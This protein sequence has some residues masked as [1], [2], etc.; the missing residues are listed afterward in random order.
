MPSSPAEPL[1][2]AE[3]VLRA[4]ARA[5]DEALQAASS[6]D[7]HAVE[8]LLTATDRLLAAP[9][10]PPAD[11]TAFEAI[12]ADARA[13]HARLLAL[14]SEVRDETGAELGRTRRGRKALGAY[15]GDPALGRRVESRA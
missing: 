2:T 9:K 15:A 1:P 11:P 10:Q 7:L 12:C 13:A 3:A 8:Q 5:Y 6:D 14:L 4:I